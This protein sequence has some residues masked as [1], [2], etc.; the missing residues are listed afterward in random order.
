[1]VMAADG[2]GGIHPR[3]LLPTGIVSAGSLLTWITLAIR[4]GL[5]RRRR[6]R[7]S[8]KEPPATP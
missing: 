3:Y 4:A 6:R 8:G 7:A 5:T 2:T 1:V